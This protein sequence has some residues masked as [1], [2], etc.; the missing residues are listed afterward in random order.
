M[1]PSSSSRH[2]IQKIVSGG[3][4]GVDR[5]A[6]DAAIELNIPCG[7]WCPKGRLAEDGVIDAKYPLTETPSADYAQRT[8]WNVR[9]SDGTLILT[10]AEPTG[11]TAFTIRVADEHG[12]PVQVV[13][14]KD[15]PEADR[16]RGVLDWLEQN[17]IGTLN[18]AGPRESTSPGIYATALCFLS[19]IQ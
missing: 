14:L 11:G 6:L 13:R 8:E 7:G 19:K 12:K 15:G 1:S 5:A 4:T 17:G 2:A 3:Q 18:V 9:D 10:I 16:V